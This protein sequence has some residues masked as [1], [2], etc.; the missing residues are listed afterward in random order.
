MRHCNALQEAEAVAE[1]AQTRHGEAGR[2]LWLC[3]AWAWG[4]VMAYVILR[5]IAREARYG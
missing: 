1:A 5:G 4:L 2:P 3:P